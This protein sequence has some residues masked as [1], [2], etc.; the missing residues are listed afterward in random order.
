MTGAAGRL[1]READDGPVACDLWDVRGRL[2]GETG[3]SEVGEV[4]LNRAVRKLF[5]G[6]QFSGTIHVEKS[7]HR[8]DVRSR[9]VGARSIALIGGDVAYAGRINQR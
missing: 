7:F 5:R 4:E 3:T 6:E 9:G 8:A 1:R 2:H